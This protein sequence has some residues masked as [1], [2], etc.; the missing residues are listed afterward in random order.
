[1]SVT[2]EIELWGKPSWMMDIEDKDKINIDDLKEMGNWFKEHLHKTAEIVDKLQ[3]NGWL[4]CECCG[5]M[6]SAPFYKE[7]SNTEKKAKVELKKLGINQNEVSIM[8]W[9]DEEDTEDE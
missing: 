9:E 7:G 3:K 2:V 1:M 8:E 5:P 4:M 6:Y